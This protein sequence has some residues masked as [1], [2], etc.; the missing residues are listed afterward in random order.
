L[1][2][3]V[4]K[5]KLEIEHFKH[6]ATI[7]EKNGDYGK[8]AELRYGK[9]REAEERLKV[10]ETNLT[11]AKESGSQ[12]LK[13]EVDS[14]D[15]TDVISAW[16]GIPVARMLQSEREKLLHLE[17]EL[18]KRVI[19]Q[20]AA[21]ESIS[22]AVRRSRAGL[23]DSKKPIGSFIFLGTTGVGKTE[24][25]KA[26]AEFLFNNENALT[27]IDMSEY[28]ERHAVSRLVGAPPG[29][30]GYEEG[31]QLTEAVRRKPYSVVLLDEIEKAHP[32]VF[33][34]LLQVLDDGRLTDNKGR[35]VNFKNTIIIMTS[36]IGSHLIQENFEHFSEE[37]RE[38]ILLKTRNEVYEL[39]K[40]T[41]RPEFLN[42]IDE[43]IMFEPITRENM[44]KIVEIQLKYVIKTLAEQDIKLTV[45]NEA[46]DWLSQLGFDP[47]FGARPVKRVIQKQVLNELSKAILA[48]KVKKEQSIQLDMFD[49]K[50]VFINQN[51]PAE[52]SAN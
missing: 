37:N 11:A 44:N 23:Q 49:N 21:I 7:A 20:E 25:A 5:L 31:G 16:T 19:G 35:T 12:L 9:V 32:D 8:V 42:R 40:K 29:Y 28:Q 47:Q 45:T 24:L 27:R 50:L 2:E 39:L 30:V 3:S 26:L 43:T 48:G 36:N 52:I 6:E 22:D 38:Q 13:E 18:H 17:D 46:I 41:I 10:M 34:I 14:E 4:Q 51:Q 1:I 33:N 15:I